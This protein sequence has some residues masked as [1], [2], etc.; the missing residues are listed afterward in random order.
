MTAAN[1]NIKV[2][3]SWYPDY[4]DYINTHIGVGDDGMGIPEEILPLADFSQYTSQFLFSPTGSKWQ[5]SFYP[6]DD[7]LTCGTP[8]APL[9]LT[10]F[11]YI[12]ERFDGTTEHINGLNELKDIIDDQG[13]SANVFPVSLEYA[14]WETDEVIKKELYRNLGLSFLCIFLTTL[15]LLADITASLMVMVCVGMV[16]VDVLG[17]MHFW[18]LTID[19]VSSINV[20]ISIGLCVDYSAH[21]AHM[22]L[23]KRGSRQERAA[24]TLY[25]IGPAVLNGGFST[26]IAT[27][28]L[29]AS[30]SH[31]FVSFF[32]IFFLVV[33]FGLFHGLIFLPIMFSLIGPRT[34]EFKRHLEEDIGDILEEGHKEKQNG[35]VHP[36]I[37]EEE[38]DDS[39]RGSSIKY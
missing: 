7:I 10:T 36:T 39:S 19:V 29:C 34:Y 21:V 12:H 24:Q 17:F 18:G 37:K 25:D 33:I 30:D 31:V 11:S 32:R 14:N 16:L 13:F 35:H 23:N 28:T 9:S 27:I 8:I 5:P 4:K 3:N 15:L 20:I 1:G 26:F 38:E 2:V 6:E 22:F